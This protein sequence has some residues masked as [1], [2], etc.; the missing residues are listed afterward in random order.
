MDR[1]KIVINSLC[2]FLPEDEIIAWT[3]EELNTYV[4]IEIL[5]NYLQFFYND[6]KSETG[7]I[8]R[9]LVKFKNSVLNKGNHDLRPDTFHIVKKSN[10]KI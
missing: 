3:E 9:Q 6:Y 5:L 10:Y 7:K 8:I 1:S 4:L 2:K